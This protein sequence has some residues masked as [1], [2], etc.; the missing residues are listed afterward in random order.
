MRNQEVKSYS[1]LLVAA[2]MVLSLSSCNYFNK[3]PSPAQAPVADKEFQSSIDATFATLLVSDIEMIGS[4][5]GEGIE[6][7]NFYNQSPA[8][9]V[10]STQGT[11]T[12]ITDIASKYHFTAFNRTLCYDGH[13]RDGTVNLR[14][15]NSTQHANYYRDYGF[16]GEITLSDYKVDGW[17]IRTVPNGAPCKVYNQ[18]NGANYD[19]TQTKLSWSIEGSFEFIHPTDPSRNMTW[20]GK[21][22]KTLA[23]STDRN[24]F[25]PS[26]QKAINWP[27]GRVEYTGWATGL[28]SGNVPYTFSIYNRLPLTRDF[29]CFPNKIGGV[30]NPGSVVWNSE[31]H[32]FIKGMVEF[33]TADLYPRQIYYGN[34]G[35]PSLPPQCDNSGEVLIKGITYKVDFME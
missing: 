28:T 31:S 2:C 34:E 15:E 14:Y 22:T 9:Y 27:M 17:L 26:K 4:F 21:L 29:N 24:V 33:K 25:D 18:L 3:K 5:T 11:L 16:Y 7:P 12:P 6:Y 19:P 32:P 35:D 30:Q 8:S 1:R 10:T 13:M 23:N 20:S